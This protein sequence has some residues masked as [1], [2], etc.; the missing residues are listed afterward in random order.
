M[1]ESVQ[2]IFLAALGSAACANARLNFD[3][4]LNAIIQL[5]IRK[6]PAEDSLTG[7]LTLVKKCIL[8]RAH[9]APECARV[10]WE[11]LPGVWK[12]MLHHNEVLHL[13]FELYSGG[14]N[15]AITAAP[16]LK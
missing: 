8:P 5:A 16:S 4:F 2:L 14:I 15:S 11:R 10:N 13:M 7:G 9:R 12:L 3:Q 6:L 1:G